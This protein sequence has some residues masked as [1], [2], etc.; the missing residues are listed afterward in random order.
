MQNINLKQ[1]GLISRL[2]KELMKLT[3]K[4]FTAVYTQWPVLEE[5]AQ[6]RK[7]RFLSCQELGGISLV[8]QW[9]GLYASSAGGTGSIS[10]MELTSHMPSS[11]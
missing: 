8:V 10:G 2:C 11:Q 1:R 4:M 6:Q 9:L 7:R 5:T 3:N